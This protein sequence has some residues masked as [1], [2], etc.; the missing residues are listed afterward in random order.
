M[1]PASSLFLDHAASHR[2][3]PAF[4]TCFD[5]I[6]ELHEARPE[7]C[8][9]DRCVRIPLP[10]LPIG[11]QVFTDTW[12][13]AVS[14]DPCPVPLSTKI[15]VETKSTHYKMSIGRRWTTRKPAQGV[16]TDRGAWGA[17]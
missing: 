16:F 6:V 7:H 17:E 8:S 1:S 10:S 12:W 5:E 14:L 15:A 11:A 3:L 13:F 4:P 2:H 9:R